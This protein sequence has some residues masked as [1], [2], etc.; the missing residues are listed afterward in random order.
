MGTNITRD[1][2]I[3]EI[4]Q[5]ST[6]FGIAHSD[7]VPECKQCDLK[8]QCKSKSE[9]EVET[10]SKAKP[11]PTATVDQMMDSAAKRIKE[12]KSRV[13]ST[14]AD[15]MEGKGALLSDKPKATTTSKTTKKAKPNKPTPKQKTTSSGSDNM[16]VFKDMSFD[17][18][19]EL[20]TERNV[21]WKEYGNQSITRMR[22]IMGL[23]SS[24]GG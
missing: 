1:A 7:D 15:P 23:K 6:C 3:L 18:L 16:P 17:E 5:E 13:K 10:S 11:K 19:C 2:R 4:M 14:M 24:Y 21:E 22:L 9:G 8:R 20:A 12:S